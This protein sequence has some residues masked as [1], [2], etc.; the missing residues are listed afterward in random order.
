MRS[1]TIWIQKYNTETIENAIDKSN[2]LFSESLKKTVVGP[3][4]TENNPTGN[5]ELDYRFLSKHPHCDECDLVESLDMEQL[6]C[7]QFLGK[8]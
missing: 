7:H 2:I 4:P 3:F 5:S 6:G 1:I 8:S